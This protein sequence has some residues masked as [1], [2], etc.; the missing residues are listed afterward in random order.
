MEND[1]LERFPLEEA[2]ESRNNA[3]CNLAEFIPLRNEIYKC[4]DDGWSIEFIWEVLVK[5]EKI[6]FSYQTF[7]ELVNKYKTNNTNK[8][9]HDL[10]TKEPE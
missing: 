3:R 8:L 2:N 6:T 1:L 5:K 10:S 4:I 9:N 7:L